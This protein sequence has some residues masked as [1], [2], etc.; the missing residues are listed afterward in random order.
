[1]IASDFASNFCEINLR[2][3]ALKQKRKD[4][5]TAKLHCFWFYFERRLEA[6]SEAKL[7]T[8]VGSICLTVR[9]IALRAKGINGRSSLAESA[10]V[11]ADEQ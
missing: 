2:S 5:T 3:K 9:S 6:K 10:L 1:V 7:E 8:K 4:H 11:V